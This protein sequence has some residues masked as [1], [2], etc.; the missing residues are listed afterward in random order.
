MTDL[1]TENVFLSNQV[2]TQMDQLNKMNAGKVSTD[3]HLNGLVDNRGRDTTK[4]GDIVLKGEKELSPS[5]NYGKG[6]VIIHEK[7]LATED[8]MEVHEK[9]VKIVFLDGK[10]HVPDVIESR[11]FASKAGALE[12]PKIAPKPKM[13]R[14]VGVGDGNVF[15]STG[16][17][18]VHEKELR[19]VYI[20]GE[21]GKGK[22]TRNVG[23]LCK[24]AMRDVGMTHRSENEH[25]GMAAGSEE[26][27]NKVGDS[28]NVCSTNSQT[29]MK[30][31]SVFSARH[32]HIRNEQ[33]HSILSEMLQKTVH[34][35]GIQCRF[36]TESKSV[37]ATVHCQ[38][39]DVGL[40]CRYSERRYRA[41]SFDEECGR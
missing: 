30:Q 34:S 27:R 37:D 5:G 21:T 7:E 26:I 14:T 39:I 15:S 17:I 22:M 38:R 18:E 8:H 12:K 19:T 33:L 29:S 16:N 23:I 1:Q 32:I 20:G 10:G 3:N 2:K 25:S 9:E 40:Q 11:N 31:S 24:A 13:S 4:N 28:R 36:A 41:S 6:N 35:V